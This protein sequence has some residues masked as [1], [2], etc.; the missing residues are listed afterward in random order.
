MFKFSS[1]SKLSQ[2]AQSDIVHNET[3]LHLIT[4]NETAIKLCAIN[5]DFIHKFKFLLTMPITP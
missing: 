5:N 2:P 4:L 3:K 1:S